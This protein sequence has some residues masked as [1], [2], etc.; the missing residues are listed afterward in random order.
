MATADIH[1]NLYEYKNK[2]CEYKK[3]NEHIYTS[4]TCTHKKREIK[5]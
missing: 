4:N 2:K 5:W 3:E 1:K